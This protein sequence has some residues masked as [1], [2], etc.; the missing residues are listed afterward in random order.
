[1]SRQVARSMLRW[2]KKSGD[3]GMLVRVQIVTSAGRGVSAATIT[4]L[5][6][7]VRSSVYRV[8]TRYIDGGRDGLR[9]ERANN[10]RR[11]ADT[12]FCSAVAQFLAG[13]PEDHGFTRPTWTRELLIKVA[14]AETGVRVSLAVMGRVLRRLG[15]RR[16]RPKPIVACPLSDR[17]RRRRLAKIRRLLETLR[18]DE[19][20]VYEDEADIHLNPKIGV[21]WMPRGVQRQVMTPGKNAKAYIAGTLDARDGTVLWVGA[22]AKTSALFVAMLERL[23]EHYVEA[24][25]IHVILDNYGIHYSHETRRALARL[26][27]IEL[28]FLPPYCPDHN[29]IERLWQD[30]H[31]NVT[32]NHRHARLEDLCGAVA[33]YLD[34]VSP[35]LRAD[36]R[37]ARA[38]D[39]GVMSKRAEISKAA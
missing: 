15:A 22:G 39:S 16:G 11:I 4:E 5:V 6:G 20:A 29:R 27:K 25:R 12:N 31:A 37:R 26:S 17:Q 32:R 24:K 18:P 9:D 13:S 34:D 38:F 10:G 2:A 30:L 23:V 3:A 7:C 8:V 28:H 33:R 14:E 21:D 1:M 35:W 36:V 19:V